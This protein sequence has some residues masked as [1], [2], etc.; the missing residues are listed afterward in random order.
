MKSIRAG[1]EP[2]PYFK[3]LTDASN[4]NFQTNVKFLSAQSEAW[5]FLS[6]LA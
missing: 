4:A 1:D 3:A 2:M 5:L 6:S